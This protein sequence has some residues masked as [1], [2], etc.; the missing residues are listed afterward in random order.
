MSGTMCSVLA[1]LLVA[2]LLPAV[3]RRQV[4]FDSREAFGN[5]GSGSVGVSG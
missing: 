1:F 4:L 5:G 2:E 3:V